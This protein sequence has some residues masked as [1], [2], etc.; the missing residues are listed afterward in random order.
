MKRLH[1]RIDYID[2]IFTTIR[3][4]N[5][6]RVLEKAALRLLTYHLS[7]KSMFCRAYKRSENNSGVRRAKNHMTFC[8]FSFPFFLCIL[9]TN[10]VQTTNQL[11]EIKI[12]M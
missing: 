1:N 7:S 10:T 2:R 5:L 12:Y 11:T 6:V 9:N 3:I 8:G 4:V